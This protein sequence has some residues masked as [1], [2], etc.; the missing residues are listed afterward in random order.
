MGYIHVGTIGYTLGFYRDNGKDDGNYYLEVRVLWI[1]DE[2][3]KET[4]PRRPSMKTRHLCSVDLSGAGQDLGGRAMQMHP[5]T[6]GD[7]A[8]GSCITT[9][10]SFACEGGHHQCTFASCCKLLSRVD[11]KESI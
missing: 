8:L 4:C 3:V 5:F 11:V 9:T 1:L 7:C 10:G 2:F 6:Q